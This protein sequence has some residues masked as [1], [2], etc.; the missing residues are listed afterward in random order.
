MLFALSF[1]VAKLASAL[2]VLFVGFLVLVHHSGVFGGQLQFA[3]GGYAGLDACSMGWPGR[4]SWLSGGHLSSPGTGFAASVLDERLEPDQISANL[5]AI[6]TQ[7][8]ADLFDQTG[9]L[10]IHFHGDPGVRVV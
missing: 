1:G 10:P 5:P 6:E 3:L 7:S 8:F 4:H 9:G 2:D